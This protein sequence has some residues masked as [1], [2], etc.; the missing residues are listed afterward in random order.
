MQPLELVTDT[1]DGVSRCGEASAEAESIDD[2]FARLEAGGQ[3]LR[4]DPSVTPTMFHV[5]R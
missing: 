3:L 2:L 4:L 1:V 5:Q